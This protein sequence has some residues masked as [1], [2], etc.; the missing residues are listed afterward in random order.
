[1]HKVGSPPP[2]TALPWRSLMLI[3][4]TR[5]PACVVPIAALSLFIYGC[6]GSSGG[7]VGAT[8][9]GGT[10][11]AAGSNGGAGTSGGAGT[12]GAAG[13]TGTAGSVTSG[14]AGAT[15]A[16]GATGTAGVSGAAGTTGS[17]GT[18]SGGTGACGAGDTNL[19]AEPT[20][21]PACTTLQAAFTAVAGTPPSEANLDTS[22]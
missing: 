4:V 7:D 6:A 1:M 8:G 22:R 18:G 13:T 10:S 16:G 19:P 5:S 3:P 2:P 12:T 21:P 15:G 17:A 9:G 11:G 20:I 14:T